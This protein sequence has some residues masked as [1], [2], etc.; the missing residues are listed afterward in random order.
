MRLSPLSLLLA[1][2]LSGCASQSELTAIRLDPADP[3][4]QTTACRQ[5][6]EGSAFHRD[7]REISMVASPL[8]LV[9]SGGL[10]LPVVA[11]NAGLDY[12]DRVD[13]SNM[14]ARCGGRGENADDI[15]RSVTTGAALNAV[16]GGTAK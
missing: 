11:A 8:L 4:Y 14:A 5:S 16:T 10:L 9:L 1:T 15:A 2:L 6:R 3:K 13:A 12:V 7:A